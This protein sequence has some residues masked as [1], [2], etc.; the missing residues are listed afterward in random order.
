MEEAIL[1]P[2]IYEQPEDTG[3]GYMEFFDWLAKRSMADLIRLAKNLPSAERVAVYR[4][5][6]HGLRER[7]GLVVWQNT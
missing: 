3:I 5:L 4:D 1:P 6:R 2:D 7:A